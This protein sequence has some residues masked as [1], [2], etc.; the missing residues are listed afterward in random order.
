MDVS[1]RVNHA[2]LP[3]SMKRANTLLQKAEN[4]FVEKI[5]ELYAAQS[6]HQREKEVLE[7]MIVALQTD[8]DTEKPKNFATIH[9]VTQLLLSS[10]FFH[11]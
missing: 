11:S 4:T 10:F 2:T 8:L 9:H 3:D 6:T 1:G 5:V 7:A